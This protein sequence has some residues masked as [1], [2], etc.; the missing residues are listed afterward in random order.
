MTKTLLKKIAQSTKLTADGLMPKQQ[1]EFEHWFVKR[2]N[3][4]N[5]IPTAE[6][7]EYQLQLWKRRY[8]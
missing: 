4:Y 8:N 2:C 3:E 1:E 6:I 5:W 7:R